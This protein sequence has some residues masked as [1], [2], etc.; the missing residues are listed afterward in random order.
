MSMTQ[1]QIEQFN[2]DGYVIVR[3]L[4]DKEEMDLLIQKAK[5][6]AGLQESAYGR[7]DRQGNTIKLALWNHPGDDLYGIFSRSRRMVEGMEAF[8]G[9]EV[10]HWH[11]KMI[12]KEPF[13]GGA[14]EW[15]QDYGYWYND[16]CLMP[17]MA[18]C[19]VALD[20]ATRENGCMQVLR[21]SHKMGRIEHGVAAGQTGADLLRVEAAKERFELVYCEMAP[22]DAMFFHGNL[23]HASSPNDSPNP[24]WS[25]ISCYNRADNSPFKAESRHPHYTP[26]QK[27]EDSAIREVAA[28]EMA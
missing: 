19:S 11:S 15:H 21:G 1:Q 3:G 24:R 14:W 23:L 22:G 25:L 9:G 6:D 12:L 7:E 18:S 10:Y 26:L 20:P 17:D 2:E 13:V 28:R 8:L 27:V 5:A 4:F 16:G